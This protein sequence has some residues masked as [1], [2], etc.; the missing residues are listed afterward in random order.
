MI[1][2]KTLLGA[3]ACVAPLLATPAG[4]EQLS[5]YTVAQLLEP[6]VEGDNDSRWGAAAEAECEQYITGFTDAYTM[7]EAS[8]QDNVCLPEGGNRPDEV[9]WAFMKW[10]HKHYDQRG[11]PAAEGLRITVKSAFACPQ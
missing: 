9:R 3:I 8:K 1:R 11:M 10:A 7:L 2:R 4:A 5:D 6:C